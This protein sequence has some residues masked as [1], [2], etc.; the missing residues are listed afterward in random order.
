MPRSARKRQPNRRRLKRHPLAGRRKKERMGL[1]LQ[2]I[3]RL[4][5]RARRQ[6]IVGRVIYQ[7][8]GTIGMRGLHPAHRPCG[9]RPGGARRRRALGRTAARRHHLAACRRT[10]GARLLEVVFHRQ[11]LAPD[12]AHLLA[13]GLDQRAHHKSQK[14]EE[15]S[16]ENGVTGPGMGMAREGG[17]AGRPPG[18]TTRARRAGRRRAASAVTRPCLTRSCTAEMRR[19]SP[20]PGTEGGG[21]GERRPQSPPWPTRS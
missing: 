21:G 18:S 3:C 8:V 5:G 6:R 11:G 14:E 16:R 4:H 20:L 19:A 7:V 17:G 9:R 2:A 12:H 13:L 10:G 1:R 15:V